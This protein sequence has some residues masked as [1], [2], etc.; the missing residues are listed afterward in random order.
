EVDHLEFAFEMPSEGAIPVHTVLEAGASLAGLLGDRAGLG[1]IV[2]VS[3]ELAWFQGHVRRSRE[4]VGR[5]WAPLGPPHDRRTSVSFC[6]SIP[7]RRET[8]KHGGRAKG[9]A[10]RSWRPAARDAIGVL[11]YRLPGR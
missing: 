3:D 11:P 7:P 4:C 5:Y 1:G 9:L 6:V 10:R 2:D 8:D